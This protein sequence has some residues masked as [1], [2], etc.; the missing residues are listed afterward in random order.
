MAAFIRAIEQFAIVLYGV[1]LVGVAWSVRAAWQANR[2]RTQTLYSL[3]REAA[4]TRIGR[5]VL[6]AAGFLV[7]G[8]LVFLVAQF[9]APSLPTNLP[10]PTPLGP[11]VTLTPTLTPFPT[12]TPQSTPTPDGTLNPTIGP[13]ETVESPTPEP[14]PASIPPASCPDPNVQITAPRDGDVFSSAFQIVGTANIPNFGF[15][16]FVLN[17]PF[18]NFED[19]TAGEVVRTPVVDGLLGV[20]DPTPLLDAAGV[21]RFS[22]VAV[23]NVGSEV[24]HCSI[25]LQFVRPTPSP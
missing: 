3:E 13:A 16:K 8:V 14:T 18:T 10:T 2:E 24:P 17:G 6:S 7:L 4:S 22:L 15:Y 19:R 21:Y 23:D 1:C 11:L 9:V 12:P 20:F 25:S 5:A